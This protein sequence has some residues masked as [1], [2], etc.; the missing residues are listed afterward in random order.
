MLFLS[1]SLSFSHSPFF[2]FYSSLLVDRTNF[3]E[4]HVSTLEAWIDEMD[5][6]LP[7]L[8]NFILPVWGREGEEGEGGKRGETR[9][10]RGERG[11]GETGERES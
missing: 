10:E 2:S 11:E 3:S 1:L 7:P 9:A 4:E 6:Q 5:S 8:R